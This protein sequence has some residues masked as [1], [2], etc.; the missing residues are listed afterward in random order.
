MREEKQVELLKETDQNLEA[1]MSH[2]SMWIDQTLIPL[3][4]KLQADQ[5][6]LRKELEG[7]FAEQGTFAHKI[8]AKLGHFV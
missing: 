2:V 4:N 5:I 7:S 6:N 8:Y 3:L 1:K